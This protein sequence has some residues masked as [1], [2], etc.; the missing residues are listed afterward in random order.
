VAGAL[1][2][3]SRFHSHPNRQ[4]VPDAWPATLRR[5]ASYLNTPTHARRRSCR[6]GR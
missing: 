4:P 2:V 6:A 5:G 3:G 1:S